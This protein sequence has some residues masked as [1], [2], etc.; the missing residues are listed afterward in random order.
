MEKPR[1][2]SSYQQ[3]HD[4]NLKELAAGYYKR[5]ENLRTPNAKNEQYVEYLDA[6]ATNLNV[7]PRKRK[8]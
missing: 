5:F 3:Q 8:D 4:E 1:Q 2:P 7:K 6:I